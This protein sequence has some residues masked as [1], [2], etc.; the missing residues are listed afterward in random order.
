MKIAII[1]PGTLP[2]PAI[3]G[4]A[5]ESLIDTFVLNAGKEQKIDIYSVTGSK[6]K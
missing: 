1:S 5:V 3:E 6:V 4:G 2:V